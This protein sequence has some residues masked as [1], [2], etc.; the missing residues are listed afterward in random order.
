M[1]LLVRARDSGKT[2]PSRANFSGLKAGRATWKSFERR[3]IPFAAELRK[4]S[5]RM[6]WED[7]R[8]R[9]PRQCARG[10]VF[11]QANGQVVLQVCW[12][13]FSCAAAQF[14]PR[15]SCRP[16]ADAALVS[17]ANKLLRERSV[18]PL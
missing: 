11:V 16:V 15:N 6:R 12:Q 2:H 4:F 10:T 7:M 14:K 13:P 5:L 1:I 18:K 3:R 9:H 17:K 8:G